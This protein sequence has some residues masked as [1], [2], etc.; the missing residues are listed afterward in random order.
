MFNWLLAGLIVAC[1]TVVGLGWV[2]DFPRGRTTNL[3]LVMVG[4]TVCV[5]AWPLT[6]LVILSMMLAKLLRGRPADGAR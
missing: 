6:L 3:L 2:W 5:M 4:F 1:G